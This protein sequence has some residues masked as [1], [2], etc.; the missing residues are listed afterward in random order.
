MKIRP[1]IAAVAATG[2]AGAAALL[3]PAYASAQP[4]CGCTAHTLRFISRTDDTRGFTAT[5][6]AIQDTDYAKGRKIGFDQVYITVNPKTGR[7]SGNFTL[8]IR[9]GVI[10]G[11]LTLKPS[12]ATGTLADGTGKFAGV[13]G[14]ISA[15]NLNKQGTRT[16]VTLRYRHG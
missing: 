1:A 15:K 6:A 3:L 12:A 11:T 13:T 7:G 4:A 16:A 9:G 8:A 10:Y 2:L 14:S 5:S